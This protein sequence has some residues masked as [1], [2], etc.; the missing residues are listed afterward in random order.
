MFQRVFLTNFLAY[1]NA[2]KHGL[3]RLIYLPNRDFLKQKRRNK[4]VKLY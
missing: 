2:T 4:I 3:E 1:E